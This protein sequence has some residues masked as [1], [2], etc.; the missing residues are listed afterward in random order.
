MAPIRLPTPRAPGA[1]RQVAQPE[2][3]PVDPRLTRLPTEAEIAEE[4]RRR[5]IGAVIVDISCDLGI[6][7]GDLDRGFWD[8]INLAIIMYGG[9]LLRFF[10]DR[11]R[12]SSAFLLGD[13]SGR[14]DPGSPVPSPRLPAPA[15]GPP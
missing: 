5:P 4:V 10:K 15:T 9:S 11:M 8:E 13:N 12:R 7:P 3:Q 2:P 1:A 14:A 6:A